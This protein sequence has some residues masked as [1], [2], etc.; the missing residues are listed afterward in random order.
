MVMEGEGRDEDGKPVRN[1]ITWSMIDNDPERL[2][3]H[4]ETSADG[5]RTWETAFDG[6]YSRAQSAQD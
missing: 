1:R 3:Q 6:L 4:W 2:R 5:G